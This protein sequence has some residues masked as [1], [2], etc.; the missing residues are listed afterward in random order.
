M[1][2]FAN[3]TIVGT[4]STVI[5]GQNGGVGMVLRRGAGGTYINGIVA[6]FSGRAISVRDAFTD[7]LRMRD[8][9]LLRNLLLSGNAANFEPAGTNFGQSTNF[10]NASI[11]STTLTPAALFASL[12]EANPASAAALDWTPAVGSPAASGGL[13]TFP[14]VVA[15]RTG[16]FVVPTTYRGAADPDGAKWWDGW[17]VYVRR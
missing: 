13:A 3:F 5:S 11:D 10:A 4:G 7:T 15:A 2:V 8:S 16:G 6:R 12:P 14:A 9:L 17:T 1:P